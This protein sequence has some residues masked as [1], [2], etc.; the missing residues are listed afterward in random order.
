LDHVTYPFTP[1]QLGNQFTGLFADEAIG[2]EQ[3]E[4]DDKRIMSDMWESGRSIPSCGQIV[5]FAAVGCIRDEGTRF[6]H[7]LKY[8][9]SRAV[10]RVVQARVNFPGTGNRWKL[11]GKQ[12][13]SWK[14]AM[15]ALCR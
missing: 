15:Q 9:L 6:E 2:L 14:G 5:I 8:A 1:I 12:R 11:W 3:H 10:Q 7:L 4:F 13:L